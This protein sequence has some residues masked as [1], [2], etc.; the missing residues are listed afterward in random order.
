MPVLWVASKELRICVGLFLEGFLSVS[1]LKKVVACTLVKFLRTKGIQD[2]KK[3]IQSLFDS[4]NNT[5]NKYSVSFMR[6][7][8]G[9]FVLLHYTYTYYLVKVVWNVAVLKKRICQVL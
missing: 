9:P 3:N 2:Q 7:N 1:G 5:T 6:L 8:V 4:L